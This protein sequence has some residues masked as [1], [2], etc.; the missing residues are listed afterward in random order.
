[1]LKAS[2]SRPL[3]G[4]VPPMVTPLKDRDTLDLAG[5]ERLVEHILAGGVHGLFLLGTTGE[6]PSLSYRVR[7]ELIERVCGQVDGRVPVLVGV[8]DTSF[9]ESV[10]LA[11]IAAEEGAAAVVLAAPY[12][13]PAGQ[14]ELME[15][16]EHIAVEMPLPVFLYNMPSHTKIKFELGTLRQA[17]ALP[18]VVGLKDSSGDLDYFR[19]AVEVI[20][21][22][23]GASLLMGPE[24]L[25]ADSLALGGH[26]GVCGGANLL[27]QLFVDVYEAVVHGD[28]GRTAELQRR[29]QQVGDSLYTIGK[30][31][32]AFIKGVKCALSCLGICDDALAEPFQ[33]F[34]PAERERVQRALRELGV[35]R[36]LAVGAR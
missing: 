21:G 34:R 33:R 9:V 16:L 17:L 23:P 24:R 6:G 8:T 20:R 2:L 13:F 15:Y 11:G 19:Q 27:P 31:S 32:S 25:L 30:H 1:M 5:L 4:I 22:F 36:T 26:G 35:E 3:R 28:A 18:N 14:P 29:I 7:C 10:N 12:Y